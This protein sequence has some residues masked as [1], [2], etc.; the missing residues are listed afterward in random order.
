MARKSKAD[1]EREEAEPL[2]NANREAF[3]RYYTQSGGRLGHQARRH[4]E[5]PLRYSGDGDAAWMD[6]ADTNDALLG[7]VIRPPPCSPSLLQRAM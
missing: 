3:C 2:D 1:K 4:G 7:L 5:L 6:R